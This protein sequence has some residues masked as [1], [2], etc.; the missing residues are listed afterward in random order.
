M[1]ETWNKIVEIVHVLLGVDGSAS[2]LNTVLSAL[3]DYAVATAMRDKFLVLGLLRPLGPMCTSLEKGKG[4]E[5]GAGVFE[6]L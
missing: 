2:S 3:W 4:D 1:V 5:G 6:L